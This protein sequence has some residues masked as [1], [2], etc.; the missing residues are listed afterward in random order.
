MHSEDHS[1]PSVLV[2]DR[3]GVVAFRVPV[4]VQQLDGAIFIPAVIQMRIAAERLAG[5]GPTFLHRIC[6]S[7]GTG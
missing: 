2:A 4:H 1:V 3:A 7:R 5:K 6:S